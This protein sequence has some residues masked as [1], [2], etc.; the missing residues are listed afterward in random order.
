[1]AHVLCQSLERGAPLLGFAVAAKIQGDEPELVGKLALGSEE[2]AMSH[3]AMQKHQGP[4]GTGVP[5][6][7]A[8]P[9][10]CRE[11]V[12]TPLPRAASLRR[13]SQ[14]ELVALPES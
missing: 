5:I 9:V 10:R 2:A 3:Q 8:R 6:R 1:M 11:I 14:L 7:Y 4:T 12:Q 13:L